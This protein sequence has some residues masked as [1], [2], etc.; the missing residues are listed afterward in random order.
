MATKEYYLGLDMGTSSVGWAVTD[1][2]Y[3]LLRAKGK[4]LW[5]VREFETAATAEERRSHR[6]SRRRRQR[7][8]VRQGKVKEIFHDAIEKEDPHFFQRLENSKY[9]I[10]DKD[11][12]VRYRYGVFNDQNYTDKDYYEQYPTIFHLR[13]EL[14]RNQ[15]PHDVRL[16]YL[17]VSNI[18]KRRGHFLNAGLGTDIANIT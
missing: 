3:H 7:E 9:H 5:G 1:G 6:V 4:D 16:V 13:C 2:E 17:A 18:F 8:I 15:Q 11:I 10:E 12:P 14:I